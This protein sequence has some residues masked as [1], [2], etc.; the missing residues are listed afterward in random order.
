MDRTALFRA[1]ASPRLG[2]GHVMRCLTLADALA[3]R[4]WRCAFDSAEGTEA[5]VPAVRRY[6]TSVTGPMD[7]VVVDHYGLDA[8]YERGWRDRAR[9]ILII[10]DLADRHHE[11]DLL[12]DQTW[13]RGAG[14]Y[15][16][17]VPAHC[18]VMTGSRYCLLRPGFAAH[19][20]AALARPRDRV[21]SVVVSLGGTDPGNAT[22]RVLGALASLQAEIHVVM[23]RGACHLDQ[24]RAA[25]A[26]LPHGRLHVD[27]AHMDALLAGADFAVGAAGTSAWERCC[28]GVPTLL[29]VL[30]DNQRLVAS[31]LEQAG[32]ARIVAESAMLDPARLRAAIEDLK[33]AG[34]LARMSSAAAAICDGLGADR[35]CSAIE[36]LFAS[37]GRE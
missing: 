10:D 5:I 27:V 13:G 4:G 2:A 18:R 8:A 34:A 21:G 16:G 20:P 30:V 35:L 6:M 12:L 37:E 22:C 1:D 25:V 3:S 24:V 31:N 14:D 15:A 9:R 32:A 23:G 28:L 33:Q 26:R 29:L 19:R 36:D 17:L 11:C 7:L